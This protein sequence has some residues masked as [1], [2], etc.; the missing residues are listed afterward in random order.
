MKVVIIRHAE[1]DFCWSRRC[2]SDGFD[3]ECSRYDNASIRKTIYRIPEIEYQYIYISELSRSRDTAGILFPAGN[4]IRSELIN[5]VPLRS[6]YD[7]NKKMP[8]WFWNISG[9]IQWFLNNPR[10]TEGR[11]QTGERASRFVRMI[12]NENI[13][14]AVVTHGFFMH[15]LL[16]EMK[17]AGFKTNKS[18]AEYK[19]GEYV[20]AEKR[21]KNN[22]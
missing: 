10:Q 9:R 15:T 1:V 6:S 17:K 5:E 7:T 13:D 20:I 19:N 14:C 4:F 8:L 12:G 11:D 2:T 21:E 3:S 18:S 22:D 16:K